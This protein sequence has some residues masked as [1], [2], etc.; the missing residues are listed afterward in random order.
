M[1]TLC[2]DAKQMV[3]ICMTYSEFQSFKLTAML[4]VC[5]VKMDCKADLSDQREPFNNFKDFK[6]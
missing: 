2:T 4:Q 5:I 1:E 6:I 3:T